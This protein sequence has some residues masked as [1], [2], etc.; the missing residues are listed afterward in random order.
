MTRGLPW[1]DHV[2]QLV[3]TKHCRDAFAHQERYRAPELLEL[4]HGDLC[5]L[6]S[7]TPKG[8]CYFLL[9]VDDTA[10]HM[11]MMLLAAKN[12]APDAIKEFK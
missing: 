9:V 5:S 7:P 10:C 11:W 4:V 12:S 6:V 3:I 2:E 1:L 8:W